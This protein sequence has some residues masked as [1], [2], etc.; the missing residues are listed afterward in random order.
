MIYAIVPAAGK[1]TRMRQPKLALPLGGKTVLEHVLAALRQGG[2]DQTLVVLGPHVRDLVPLV[3][4]AGAHA[5]VLAQ[6]TADMRATVEGGLC[7][8]ESLFEPDSA[9]AWL[10]APAD[11][12]TLDPTVVAQLLE[13]HSRE[14]RATIF[15]PSYQGRRGHPIL[16]S[17]SHVTAIRELPPQLG[18]N[19]Y[20]RQHPHLTC[21][22]LVDS[23][24]ILRDLDTPEDYERLCREWRGA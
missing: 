12:P 2:V 11:H 1:S 21:E 19:T 24:E 14:P 6:E 20:L 4:G 22:I 3:R 9:D 8:L 23:A 10:V 5:H 15:V 13:A 17:W 7:C 18:L 16:L